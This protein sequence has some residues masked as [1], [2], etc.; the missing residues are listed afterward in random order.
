MDAG[1]APWHG[2]GKGTNEWLMFA[3]AQPTKLDGFRTK[4]P[5]DWDG[6]SFKD[7]RFEESNDG[8]HWKV[9]KSGQGK[10]QDCKNTDCDWQ[11]IRWPS[12]TAKYF[13]LFMVNNW[14][15][16]LHMCLSLQCAQPCT[17]CVS[18]IYIYTYIQ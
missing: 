9:I 14:G 1:N 8:K 10:N 18:D 3:F 2:R 15:C 17:Q 11:E 7:Y 13:R 4:A 16:V 12:T 6:S 5:K